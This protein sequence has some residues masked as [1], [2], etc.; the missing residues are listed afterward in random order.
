MGSCC[1]LFGGAPSGAT[2]DAAP[3]PHKFSRPGWWDA[4]PP[5]HTAVRREI[6]SMALADQERFAAAMM[7]MRENSDGPGSSPY[8]K[9]AVVH[10]GMP[11]LDSAMYPEYCAHGRE[12]FPTWHRPYMLAFEQM[13]QRADMAL[14][15]D[16]RIALPYWDWCDTE[17]NG[18]VMPRVVREK[19][20]VEFD[21]DFFLTKPSRSAHGY[22]MD[23]TRSDADIKVLLEESEIAAQASQCLHSAEHAQHATT[24]YHDPRYA[25]ALESPHNAVHV[26]VGGMMASFQAPPEPPHPR[27]ARAHLRRPLCPISARVSRAE[28]VPPDLLAPPRQRRSYLREVP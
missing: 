25:P 16:G 18:E 10:G 1:S 13:L 26:I 15:G 14:G 8:F 3:Y 6:R 20:M 17:V 22:R 28:L 9:L 24:A 27:P 5:R 23:A 19:L 11:P 7:K 12:C 4:E 2:D 21:D